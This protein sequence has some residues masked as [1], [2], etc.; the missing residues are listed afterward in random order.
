VPALTKIDKDGNL[1]WH[2]HLPR[3]SFH[4]H[5][6]LIYRTAVWDICSDGADGFYFVSNA[7][8]FRFSDSV[9][10]Y[11]SDVYYYGRL[12]A[13]GDT[14]WTKTFTPD[15]SKIFLTEQVSIG[16]QQN[17][18]LVIGGTLSTLGWDP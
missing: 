11:Y 10:N 8:A 12:N 6:N 4:A 16:R 7:A 15:T 1:L 9:L 18:D 2:K 13:A 5:A 14:L 17:G 3:D